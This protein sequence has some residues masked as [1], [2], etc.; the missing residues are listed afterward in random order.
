MFTE[1]SLPDPGFLGANCQALDWN[2]VRQWEDLP[3][4]KVC[5][6]YCCSLQDTNGDLSLAHRIPIESWTPI[7]NHLMTFETLSAPYR[8]PNWNPARSKGNPIENQFY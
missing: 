8:M 4:R 3:L 7:V 5:Y 6:K 1:C 2:P